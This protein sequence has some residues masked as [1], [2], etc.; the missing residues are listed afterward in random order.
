MISRILVALDGSSRAPGVL[1]AAVDIASRFGATLHP[2]R[3]I[4]V[5]PEFPA[6]GA[7]TRADP[8]PAYLIAAARDEVGR[9]VATF[10]SGRFTIASPLVLV[11]KPSR[12][13]I[14][15]AED[16][17]VDLIVIGSHGYQ[18]LDRILGTT[19]GRVANLAQ[20][21]VLVVHE[22]TDR[23]EHMVPSGSPYRRHAES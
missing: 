11:G 22:R 17:D 21:N 14:D 3:A 2:L 23:P 1:A 7:G 16:L 20:R 4:F 18:G 10:P 5:P 19:A 12:L 9:L 8:L 15:A 6:A 13:I